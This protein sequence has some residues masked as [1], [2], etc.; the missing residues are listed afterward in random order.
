MDKAITF[1]NK[2]SIH[3]PRWLCNNEKLLYLGK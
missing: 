2:K 1:C 3:V